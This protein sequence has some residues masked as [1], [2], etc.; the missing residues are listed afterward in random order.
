MNRGTTKRILGNLAISTTA[1]LVTPV[2]LFLLSEN[3]V[4]AAVL[5]GG[6]VISLIYANAITFL[7]DATLPRLGKCVEPIN[8]LLQWVILIVAL[9]TVSTLGWL[10][11]TRVLL[12]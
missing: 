12:L 9:I 7:A 1:A 3:P 11:A 5:G 10:F 2:F 8:P 6:L 4:G